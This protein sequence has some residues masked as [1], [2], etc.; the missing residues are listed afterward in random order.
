[1]FDCDRG[2]EPVAGCTA[3][4]A[5]LREIRNKRVAACRPQ[6]KMVTREAFY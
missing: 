4:Y 6:R 3:G 1:M 5:G 2:D